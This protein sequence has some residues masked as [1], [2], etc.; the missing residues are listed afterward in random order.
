MIDQNVFKELRVAIVD[1]NV[2]KELR[3]AIVDFFNAV[4]T[5]EEICRV[6]VDDPNFEKPLD[7][8]IKLSIAKMIID[9][10]MALPGQKFTAWEQIDAIKGVG[11]STWHN[12]LTTFLLMKASYSP[13]QV[14]IDGIFSGNVLAVEN[15]GGDTGVI[16]YKDG[17]DMVVKKRPGPREVRNVTIIKQCT[18]DS[19]LFDWWKQFASG[20]AGRTV[21]TVVFVNAAGGCMRKYVL[22]HVWP[23]SYSVSVLHENNPQLVEKLEIAVEEITNS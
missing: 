3:V 23:V 6:V 19:R 1:Q 5:P 17:V 2:F 12:I 16:T 13:V 14:T 7:E 4:A 22:E 20:I 10:R 8:G 15:I 11:P 21:A 18:D 9:C